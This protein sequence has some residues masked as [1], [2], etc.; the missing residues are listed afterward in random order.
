[1][2]RS[3]GQTTKGARMRIQTII[4]L[5]NSSMLCLVTFAFATLM[6]SSALQGVQTKATSSQLMPTYIETPPY[7]PLAYKARITGTVE[8]DLT[9]DLDGRVQSTHLLNGHPLLAAA[10]EKAASLW[11]FD[12]TLDT[13]TTRIVRVWLVYKLIPTDAEG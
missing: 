9:L 10:S 6:T 13:R 3:L 8:V 7:P 5:S 12:R 2:P 11:R 1:M 4:D